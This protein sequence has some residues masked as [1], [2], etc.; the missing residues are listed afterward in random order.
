ML[1]SSSVLSHRAW[2]GTVRLDCGALGQRT[3]EPRVALAY[4]PQLGVGGELLQA[5][6][7]NRLQEVVARLGLGVIAVAPNE[8]LVEQRPHEIHRVAN[9]P[10]Q[11]L[12]SLQAKA[13]GEDGHAS[14]CHLW[15]A[16]ETTL[17]P[18]QQGGQRQHSCARGG[19]LDGKR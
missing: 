13:I 7:A 6:L 2:I 11:R 9:V 17:E 1:S 12:G 18:G 5:V 3:E 10:D 19:E 8:T 14:K 15:L 4:V 16:Q